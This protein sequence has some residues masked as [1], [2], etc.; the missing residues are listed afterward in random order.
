LRRWALLRPRLIG[1]VIVRRCIAVQSIGFRRYLPVGRPEVAI[2]YLDRWGVD[3]IAVLD[4]SAGLEDRS[5]SVKDVQRWSQLCQVPLTVGGGVRK[6]QEFE[7]LIRAGAD[8]V[9][10]NTWAVQEPDL[11]AGAAAAF[12]VQAVVVSVDASRNAV[13][14]WEVKTESASRPTGLAPG[15]WAQRAATLGA[16]E[17]LLTSIDRDGARTG[18]DLRLVAEVVQRVDIPVIACGG[19]GHPRHL[20]DG[21]EAGASAVAVA[22]ALNYTEHSVIA[23]KAWLSCHGT[24]FRADTYARYDGRG[25][26]KRGRPSTVPEAALERLRFE[27]IPEERI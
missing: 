20:S 22:N 1:V 21:V 19:A 4:I 12:G 8:K 13:G 18:Y 15:D 16:G 9:A 26:D 17:I 24:A 3:E 14:G 2:E 25:F 27:Y 23:W 5:V 6:L 11:I 10:L 7:A